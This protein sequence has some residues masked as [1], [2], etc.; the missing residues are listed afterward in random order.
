M[1]GGK[2]LHLIS[3][4]YYKGNP[5]VINKAVHLALATSDFEGLLKAL[6]AQ[7]ISYGDWKG[8]PGQVDTRSDGVRQ[9]F[10]QDPNGYWIEINSAGK[11]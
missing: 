3:P 4:D 8:A 9:I 7:K 11:K 10:L 6:D 5:V 1:G 2:E